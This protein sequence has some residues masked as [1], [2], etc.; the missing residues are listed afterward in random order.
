MGRGELARFLCSRGVL[1]LVPSLTFVEGHLR[2]LN[3]RR[4]LLHTAHAA[5]PP[6][7]PPGEDRRLFLPMYS[8]WAGGAAAGA[9]LCPWPRSPPSSFS[10]LSA[11]SPTL[12]S[13]CVFFVLLCVLAVCFVLFV[14]CAPLSFP[15]RCP[16]PCGA[17]RAMYDTH[18]LPLPPSLH[19]T[20]R[21]VEKERQEWHD[22]SVL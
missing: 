4:G 8:T 15:T 9:S 18:T 19:K 11:D 5:P 16:L 13:R 2:V 6:L 12:R 7:L 3:Q 20:K 1:R 22:R 10:V 21:F 14:W 17:V